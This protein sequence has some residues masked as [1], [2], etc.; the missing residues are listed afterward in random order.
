MTHIHLMAVALL[1]ALP[2]TAQELHEETFDTWYSFIL[3]K[4]SELAWRTIGWRETLGK[5]WLEAQ[6]KERP[7]L[8]WAMNGHPLGCT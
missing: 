3:P 8:L 5:A 4:K 6:K 7:I 1:A 2:L